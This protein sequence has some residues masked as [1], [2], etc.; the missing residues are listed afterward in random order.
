MHKNIFR[1]KIFIF[2]V[3]FVVIFIIFG[4]SINTSDE[5]IFSYLGRNYQSININNTSNDFSIFDEDTEKNDVILCGEAHAVKYNYKLQLQLLEYFNKKNNLKYLLAE[6][7]YS[8]SCYI[9][10]YLETGNQENLKI[11]IG[12]L[13]NTFS[14]NNDFYDFWIKLRAYNLSLPQNKRIKV[15]GVDIEHEIPTAVKYLNSIMDKN[16]NVPGEI[17]VGINK[18]KQSV[19]YRSLTNE[20]VIY[21]NSDL[22]K[23]MLD[24]QNY[25][26]RNENIFKEYLG[27]NYFDFNFIVNNIVNSINSYSASPN[28]TQLVKIREK[29]IYT[30]FKILYNHLPKN[31]YFG[32]FGEEH[33][34]QN[35]LKSHDN[36]HNINFASYLNDKNSPVKG[37]VLSVEY[38]YK[39][40]YYMSQEQPYPKEKEQYQIN[41]KDDNFISKYASSDVTIYKLDGDYSPF[42]KKL[43]FIQN[44][45]IKGVTT[46]YYKYIILIKNSTSES[47]YTIRTSN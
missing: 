20:D 35:T 41:S 39:N 2:F 21:K 29:F 32:Q 26:K 40:C 22:K 16:I 13:Q 11:I 7:P 4:C 33:V 28:F 36:D 38:Y 18:F 45:N 31:K 15:V 6:L 8:T 10:D 5:G 27:S 43:F 47:M 9:N 42:S 17:A 12:N 37:K 14:Y 44:T 30:N 25:I 1:G 23:S 34:Y 19:N 3:L 24:F 46:D